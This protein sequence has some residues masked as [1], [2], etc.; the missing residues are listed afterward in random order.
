MT[1]KYCPEAKGCAGLP[2]R[3]WELEKRLGEVQ[4][5]HVEL[6]PLALLFGCDEVVGLLFLTDANY[7]A[8][9]PLF[10]P[11][12]KDAMSPPHLAGNGLLRVCK[13]CKNALDEGKIPSCSLANNLEWELCR[14]SC[15][16]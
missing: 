3:A 9:D 2:R 11:L 16:V 13:S 4:G 10:C 15:K 7:A 5:P 12:K 14:Q 6:G 8:E 1:P